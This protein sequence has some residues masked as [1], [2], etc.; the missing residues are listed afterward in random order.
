MIGPRL[1]CVVATP[2]AVDPSP[3]PAALPSLTNPERWGWLQRLRNG[4]WPIE[5]W[6]A[7]IETGRLALEQDLLQ[8]LADRLDSAAVVRLLSWWLAQPQRDS[9]LPERICRLRSAAVAAALRRGLSEHPEQ[10]LQAM[11]LPLLGHQRQAADFFLLRRMVLEPASAAVRRAALE[12]LCLGL[13]AW[14]LA[15]LRSTLVQ[16]GTDL[17]PH[18]A[19][20]AVDAL[21]R[22]PDGRAS[23][24]TLRSA[25]LDTAVAA[26]VERRLAALPASPLLLLV[27]GRAEGEIPSELQDLAAEL[28]QRRR[29]PVL[30]RAL[31]DPDP[32]ALP[33]CDQPFWLVPLLLLPG[34]HVRHD[35]PRLRQALRAQCRL[36]SLPFLGS[37]PAWQRALGQ[38][39]LQILSTGDWPPGSEPLLLHHPVASPLAGRYLSHL[40]AMTGARGL[41]VPYNLNTTSLIETSLN[42][43]SSDATSSAVIMH[44][45][46][47]HPGPLVPLT[48]AANRLSNAL[49]PVFGASVAAPLLARAKLRQVLL[50][51]LEVLP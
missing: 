16:L 15:R 34:E 43:T 44:S 24:V 42:A 27:H 47:N 50:E 38:E 36:R 39:L 35:L 33:S 18:L 46:L 4:D 2:S 1:S 23:L 19:A 8:A 40:S 9:A 14:P 17:D 51:R 22:L 45:M 3:P 31:T 7:A 6:L 21:A 25:S 5:P 12:G 37:W 48:L 11:L 28:Q 13:S 30:L 29:S 41:E 10:Q 32:A 26:R 20:S 49:L